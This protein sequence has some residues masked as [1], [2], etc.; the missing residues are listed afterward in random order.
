MLLAIRRPSNS[1]QSARSV[2]THTTSREIHQNGFSAP[3]H[4]KDRPIRKD[5]I[6]ISTGTGLDLQRVHSDALPK[7]HV[8]PKVVYVETSASATS[9][10][11]TL[12]SEDSRRLSDELVN[13]T[14]TEFGSVDSGSHPST[15]SGDV[16]DG[17]SKGSRSELNGSPVLASVNETLEPSSEV[18]ERTREQLSESQRLFSGGALVHSK[19]DEEGEDSLRS[20]SELILV[21]SRTEDRKRVNA[22]FDERSLAAHTKQSSPSMRATSEPPS[23]SSGLRMS[24]AAEQ[25]KKSS[26]DSVSPRL[27]IDEIWR[28]VEASSLEHSSLSLVTE[29]EHIDSPGKDKEEEHLPA[30]HD[31]LTAT[32]QTDLGAP[33]SQTSSVSLNRKSSSK[34]QASKGNL[35]THTGSHKI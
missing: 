29:H 13:S 22:S 1:A 25:T 31:E 16:V 20:H 23:S 27:Q 28:E 30:Q 4:H 10:K 35:H 19:L 6:A 26:L 21:S 7:H 17:C 34:S 18:H 24:P 9:N 32:S 33:S 8:A 2:V 15:S 14:A 11:P 5:L 3:P 12:V